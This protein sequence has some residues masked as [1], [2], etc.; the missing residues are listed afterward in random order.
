MTI[1]LRKARESDSNELCSILNEIID[2]GGTTGFESRLSTAEFLSH[3]LSEPSC[4]CCF[5]AEENG[6]IL[7]F[8]SLSI[9]PDL[10]DGWADIATF[11][12]V[13]PKTKG[14]G[15]S[16]FEA[17]LIHVHQQDVDVINATIRSDNMAGMNYY[18]K[19][20]FEKYSVA[21]K[22]P[23]QDGTPVDRISKK[24]IVR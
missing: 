11:A 5:L 6:L 3:F 13:K 12:R 14:V 23:L 17:T 20:G 10:P 8:Q 7:G 9:H 1:S 15:T 19:I 16:L 4:I 18:S 21:E 24:Y 2:I 22:I